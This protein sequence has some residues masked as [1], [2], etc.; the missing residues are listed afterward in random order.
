MCHAELDNP[1]HPPFEY[2]FRTLSAVWQ[3]WRFFVRKILS[4]VAIT[5]MLIHTSVRTRTRLC[6]HTHTFARAPAHTCTH[7]TLTLSLAHLHALMRACVCVLSQSIFGLF[8][9]KHLWP[10]RTKARLASSDKSIFGL[11]AQKHHWPLRTQHLGPLRTKASLASSDKNTF[12]H[13]GQAPTASR[14][15]FPT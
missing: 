13:S 14:T 15:W 4:Q 10:L 9:Q 3:A 7:G 5:H 12:G 8:G 2:A 6:T 1:P 11:F